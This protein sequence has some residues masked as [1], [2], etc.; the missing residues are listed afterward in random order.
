MELSAQQ[1]Y[2]LLVNTVRGKA[3][4]LVRNAEK[5]HAIAAWRRVKTEYQPDAAG[6][7]TAMFT[8]IMQPGLDS[9]GA[10]NTFLDQVTEWE[11]RIQEH[12][13]ESLETFSGGMEIAVLAF[14][15]LESIRYVVRL[16]AGPAGGKCRVVRQNMSE[17]LHVGRIFDKNGP[18]VESE[19]SSASATP[20]NF[21]AFHTGK[22]IMLHIQDSKWQ[23]RSQ[24]G[25]LLAM[26]GRSKKTRKSTPL[27]EHRR[28]RR[29]RQWKTRRSMKQ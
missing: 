2:C 3:L 16:A 13:G 8:G 14:H 21:D 20:I 5:H 12:E 18:G 15:A 17:F 1:L 23:E 6:R 11:R 19:P 22:K 10:A 28:L 27:M 4:T 9:R 26:S 29:W 25:R 7:H 24:V